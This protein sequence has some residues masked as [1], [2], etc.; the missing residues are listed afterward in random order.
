MPLDQDPRSPWYVVLDHWLPQ[1]PAKLVLTSAL[2]NTMKT[3]L[4]EKEFWYFIG[5]LYNHHFKGKK[6]RKRK[7]DFWARLQ[8]PGV[9]VHL[10]DV[11]LYGE[12]TRSLKG[13]RSR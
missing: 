1:N 7:L 6:F 8:P 13:D 11:G 10:V 5:Q 4:T 9:K 12:G 3:D 2:F